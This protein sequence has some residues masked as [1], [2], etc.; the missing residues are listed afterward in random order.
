MTENGI[1]WPAAVAPWEVCITALETDPDSEVM[2]T[3]QKIYDELTAAGVSVLLM[4]VSY[5]RVAS[6][7]IPN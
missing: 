1:I 6:L 3:A 4:T 7:R 2:Q 5:G